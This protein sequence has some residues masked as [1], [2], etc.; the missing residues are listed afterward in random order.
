MVFTLFIGQNRKG[1]IVLYINH[2]VLLQCSIVYY[3]IEQIT[4]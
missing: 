1:D 4:K 2:N 3:T